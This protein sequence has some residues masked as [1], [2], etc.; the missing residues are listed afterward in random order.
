MSRT[1]E[2]MSVRITPETRERLDRIAASLDRSRNW[3]VAEAIDHYL[4]L[5]Q[6]QTELIEDRLQKAESGEGHVTPHAEVMDRLEAKM[7][8]RMSG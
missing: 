7:N 5:Y 4:D 3:L 2:N 8:A 6:W 1:T